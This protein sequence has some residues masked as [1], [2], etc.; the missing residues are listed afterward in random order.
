MNDFL[1]DALGLNLLDASAVKN[2]QDRVQYI[3]ENPPTMICVNVTLSGSDA[4][5][6]AIV[7][8]I[9]MQGA[10]LTSDD[11]DWYILRSGSERELGKMA[12]IH[13]VKL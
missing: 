10:N 7:K 12:I 3:L 9:I 4:M 6:H 11:A 5:K 8:E 13:D 2:I 1:N